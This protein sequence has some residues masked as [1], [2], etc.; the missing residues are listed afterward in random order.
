MGVTDW[1]WNNGKNTA[2]STV[3]KN[4]ADNH[5]LADF[6]VANVEAGFWDLSWTPATA[7]AHLLGYAD[8]AAYSLLPPPNG[9]VA[10]V[11]VTVQKTQG[12]SGSSAPVGT[13][14]ASTMGITSMEAK[15]S[16]VA[17]ISPPSTIPYSS[18]FPFALPWTLG[19]ESL[20]R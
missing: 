11:K 4:F 3:Q 13:Y 18:A 12:G 20:G 19:R 15:C 10:A 2:V 5:S 7:P 6:T 16:A 1:Q 9:Q 17:M 14:F 8:P